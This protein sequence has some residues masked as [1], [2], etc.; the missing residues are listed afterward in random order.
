MRFD[1]TNIFARTFGD[2]DLF[3][4]G[5][6]VLFKRSKSKEMLAYLIYKAG[7]MVNRKEIAAI[8]FEDDYSE[9]TQ[10]YIA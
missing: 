6:A 1:V 3:V 9:K 8:L 5:E 4:D 10:N 2:F 7:G